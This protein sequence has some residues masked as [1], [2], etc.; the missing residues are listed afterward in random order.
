MPKVTRTTVQGKNKRI[1]RFK[2]DGKK[3]NS[4]TEMTKTK[5]RKKTRKWIIDYS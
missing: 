4:V 2:R 5:G 3:I 1:R